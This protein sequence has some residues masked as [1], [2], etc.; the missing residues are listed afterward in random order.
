MNIYI[1]E[2]E[3]LIHLIHDCLRPRPRYFERDILPATS[4][5]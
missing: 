3:S 5:C 1:I 4:S 2:R